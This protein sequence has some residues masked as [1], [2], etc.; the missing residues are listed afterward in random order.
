MPWIPQLS[1]SYLLKN[2][3]NPVSNFH[4]NDKIP[5]IF[6]ASKELTSASLIAKSILDSMKE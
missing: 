3:N 4:S 5:K 6:K 2:I 1:P